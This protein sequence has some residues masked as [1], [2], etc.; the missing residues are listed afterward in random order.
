MRN[1]GLRVVFLS[2]E[3]MPAGKHF[4]DHNYVE[5]YVQLYHERTQIVHNNWI[6][7]HNDKKGRFQRHHL[8]FVEDTPFPECGSHSDP[9]QIGAPDP[10]DTATSG[11]RVMITTGIGLSFITFAWYASTSLRARRRRNLN[12]R[13]LLP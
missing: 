13:G 7:G 4:F 11:E 1:A 12:V 3:V 2:P 6:K 9:G 5:N 10:F 8:W